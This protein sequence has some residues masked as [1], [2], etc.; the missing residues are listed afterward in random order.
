MRG[1]KLKWIETENELPD[2]DNEVLCLVVGRNNI[3]VY[4]ILEYD[5][6]HKEWIDYNGFEHQTVTHWMELPEE[7]I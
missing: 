3:R 5:H 4:R 7:P 1:D 2:H 6:Q